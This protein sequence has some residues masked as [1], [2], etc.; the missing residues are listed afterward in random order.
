MSGRGATGLGRRNSEMEMVTQR[1]T[2]V[3]M[4]THERAQAHAPAH[5]RIPGAHTPAAHAEAPAFRTKEGTAEPN[6]CGDRRPLPAA[7]L[8]GLAQQAAAPAG[9]RRAL[10]QH[11]QG[12]PREREERPLGGSGEG[13]VPAASWAREGGGG[14]R[15][16]GRGRSAYKIALL[17]GINKPPLA[18]SS[19]SG[20]QASLRR[21]PRSL[22]APPA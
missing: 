17:R 5:K 14:A 21:S 22:W 4:H 7:P 3:R 12:R 20:A 6:G 18:P 9:A 1:H 11:G 13:C 10:P 15:R 19:G 8:L 2:E 16:G